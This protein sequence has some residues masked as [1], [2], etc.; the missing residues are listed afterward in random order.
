[1]TKKIVICIGVS[2]LLAAFIFSCAKSTTD[3]DADSTSNAET[4]SSIPSADPVS[5]DY[6]LASTSLMATLKDQT[7]N[8]VSISSSH[9]GG[10]GGGSDSSLKVKIQH[11]EGTGR[12]TFKVYQCKDTT[13]MAFASYSVDS[14]TYSGTVLYRESG[15]Y[16]GDN[17]VDL[18]SSIKSGSITES[19]FAG[20][21]DFRINSESRIVLTADGATR[22][23][24]LQGTKSSHAIS[25]KWN[26]TL[27]CAG[28]QGQDST[29]PFAISVDATTKTKTY[30]TTADT[31]MCANMSYT[32]VA[33]NATLTTDQTWDCTLPSGASWIDVGS[34]IGLEDSGGNNCKTLSDSWESEAN[35]NPATCGAATTASAAGCF[36]DS[37]FAVAVQKVRRAERQF[38]CKAKG[39]FAMAKAG[40]ISGVK[41][42]KNDT[43]YLNISSIGGH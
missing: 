9:G 26:A 34:A 30:S 29:V 20:N 19:G 12:G 32:T 11:V 8:S 15:G 36:C 43:I 39:L 35:T 7:S 37:L 42:K 22:T 33:S 21:V 17:N 23:N 38:T 16:Y 10:Y 28:Y 3:E 6:S 41:L 18:I 40:S 27:G 1:M 25:C 31:S 4:M 5:L 13:Q 14:G 24:T 2:S